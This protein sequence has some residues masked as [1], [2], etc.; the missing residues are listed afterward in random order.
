MKGPFSVDKILYHPERISEFLKT[1]TTFPITWELD[2]TNKCNQHCPQCAGG[3]INQGRPN[4]DSLTRE[5][6]ENYIA[7]LIL[8]GA[9]AITFTGGGEPLLAPM[10]EAMTQYAHLNGADVGL[11]TNGTLLSHKRT[12]LY[13]LVR[14]CTWIRISLDAGNP[15][16]Y[17]E[18][19]GCGKGIFHRVVRGTRLLVKARQEY[20]SSCSIGT[21]FLTSAKTKNNMLEFTELSRGLGVDYAQFRPFHLD[22]TNIDKELARCKKLEDEHFKVRAS[23]SKYQYFGQKR[24]YGVCYGHH[25]AGVINVHEVYLCC[26]FRG[27][28]R[29]KL[30]D[31]REQTLAD[32]WA[33]DQRKEVY[34]NIRFFDCVPACRC[35]PFNRFLWKLKEE[36]P[37]H[38]NFL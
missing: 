34:E 7:Q 30:G 23:I 16:V 28:P 27:M 31:L 5:E 35:D 29:Y 9:K 17:K 15:E 4:R 20:D 10:A 18:T 37:M 22:E 1:G 33:S 19:H 2:L 26:H 8:G 32:I 13:R 25:F 14:N 12:S 11:I 3:M 24:P 36:R 38:I 21:A 6:A